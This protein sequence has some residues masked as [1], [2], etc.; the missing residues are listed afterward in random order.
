M[1]DLIA[2]LAARHRRIGQECYRLGKALLQLKQQPELLT[3]YGAPSFEVFVTEHIMPFRTAARYMLVAKYFGETTVTQHGISKC[4]QIVRLHRIRRK[5]APSP[6]AL[7]R[8]N[9]RLGPDE[10]PLKKMTAKE[11]EEYVR[12]CKLQDAA[13]RVPAPT[14]SQAQ[15]VK[16]FQRELRAEL[17]VSG[18]AHI[19]TRRGTLLLRIPLDELRARYG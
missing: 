8:K 19:D 18:R 1:D 12:Q 10:R 16:R 14:R 4:E 6:S 13:D 3:M 7:L 2:S 9:P 17:G 15:D 11:L 5:L